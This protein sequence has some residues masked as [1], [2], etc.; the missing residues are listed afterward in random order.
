MSSGGLHNALPHLHK[1]GITFPA[2]R[3]G[4]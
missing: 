4:F 3:G 1:V 2:D